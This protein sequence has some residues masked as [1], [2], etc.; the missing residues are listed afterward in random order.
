V[1]IDVFWVSR[2]DDFI[3]RGYA[4]CG[5]LEEILNNRL[6]QPQY[7]FTFQHHDV[8]DEFP[9]HDGGVVCFSGMGNA[10]DAEWILAE[11]DKMAWSL[12]I[13]TG[14]EC[15]DFPWGMIPTTNTR[16][17]WVMNPL[18]EHWPLSNKIPGGWYPKTREELVDH[19]ALYME[20]P[21]DWFFGGQ[22]TNVRRQECVSA[23]RRRANG[24]LIKTDRFMGGV[25]S[26]EYAQHAVS[27]KLIPCP[28]GPM[29][30]D[31]N[32]PLAALEAGCIPVLDLIKPRDPQ[33]DYWEIVFGEHPLPTVYQ[34]S[35]AKEVMDDLLK[36]W[37]HHQAV[38]FAWW[39]Q[40]K[41]RQIYK[42][43]DDIAAVSNLLPMRKLRDRI[44]VIITSSPIPSHPDTWI[45]DETIR[46][47]RERLPECEIIVG[48]D[49][50]RREQ[51]ELASNYRR[52]VRE[53]LWKC[54]F[55]WDNVLPVVL[56][57]WGHQ[58]NLTRELLKHV[59]TPNILFVE[60][61][62]PIVGD[63][64]WED[65]LEQVENG[66]AN[67]IRLHQDVEIHP[68]H[69]GVM[70][71]PKPQVINGVRLRR[72][73]AWWQRP[74]IADTTFYREQVVEPIPLDSRTMIEDFLYGRVWVD[75]SSTRNGWGRWKIWIYEPEGDIRRSG[76]LDGRGDAPKFDMDFGR[77]R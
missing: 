25:P 17:I 16:R 72:T 74:H 60:H 39:Q 63:I 27:A 12:V 56:N 41:R 45:L 31:A 70:L 76:H 19:K 36:N 38:C 11:L 61:D 13:I 68:D 7:G 5:F 69:Y 3:T 48:F 30:L 54:N 77:Q 24:H 26:A 52:Y 14:N 20:K 44:S 32:R 18:P 73:Q 37:E 57:E 55:E 22:V 2:R 43:H 21:L 29:T 49:G 65:L 6:W 15:W 35:E 50:V 62:T 75:C 33:F 67:V 34:W 23:I 47:I 28:S 40:W 66:M 53:C 59:R 9:H 10:H 46:S 51:T 4:D 58:A 1:N 64:P 8:R 71:D 42:L